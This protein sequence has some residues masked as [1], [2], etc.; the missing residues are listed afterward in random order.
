M[1]DGV[2]MIVRSRSGEDLASCA[3]LV[4]ESHRVDGYPARLPDDVRAFLDAPD[5]I[6]A[7]VAESAGEIIGHVALH[8]TSSPAVMSL[9]CSSTGL[10][11]DRFGVVARLVVSPAARGRG[12]GSSLLRAAAS[13]SIDRGLHPMLDVHA[14]LEQAIR[15]YERSGWV[16]IGAVKVTFQ[17]GLAIDEFVYLVPD[18]AH[19]AW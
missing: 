4:R 11:A 12:V 9:A 18:S 14:A 5:A 13:A 6:A 1:C 15:L 10:A 2:T 17:N 19:L 7:W 3:E 16:R 8:P